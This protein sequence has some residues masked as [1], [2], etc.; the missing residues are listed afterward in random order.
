MRKSKSWVTPRG[1]HIL[2]VIFAVFT[3]TTQVTEQWIV[4]GWWQ[5]GG[6]LGAFWWAY[7]AGQYRRQ[8]VIE[9][10]LEAGHCETERVFQTAI[11]K[12]FDSTPFYREMS[13]Y[14]DAVK[15]VRSV[16]R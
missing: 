16:G 14:S 1:R 10:R 7:V 12:G 5:A 8:V 6:L 4:Q 13:G 9:N 3:G 11:A 15:H 2:V